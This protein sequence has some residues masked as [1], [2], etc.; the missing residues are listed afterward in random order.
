MN[1]YGKVFKRCAAEGRENHAR[2]KEGYTEKRQRE[3]SNKPEASHC[4]RTIRSKKVGSE[5]S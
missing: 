2:E 3:K 4:D 1:R 5:S